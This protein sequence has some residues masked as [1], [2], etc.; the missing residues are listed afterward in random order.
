MDQNR[1]LRSRKPSVGGKTDLQPA[2]DQIF[3]QRGGDAQ[4]LLNIRQ[5]LRADSAPGILPRLD[6]EHQQQAGGGGIVVLLDFQRA[7]GGRRA[8]MDAAQRSPGA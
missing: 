1:F 4:A 8:P 6:V 3:R 7:G 2:G 5:I